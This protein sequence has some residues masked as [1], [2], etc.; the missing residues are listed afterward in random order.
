MNIEE[1]KRRMQATH[2]SIN[3]IIESIENI[4]GPKLAMMARMM[5]CIKQIADLNHTYL[6]I[7][8]GAEERE[9]AIDA[10]IKTAK[11][12]EVLLHT[13]GSMAIKASDVDPRELV[14]VTPQMDDIIHRIKKINKEVNL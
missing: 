13:A 2:E 14:E 11:V 10:F 8:A 12:V 3:E 7:L 9:E 4:K 5:L 1:I 6:H